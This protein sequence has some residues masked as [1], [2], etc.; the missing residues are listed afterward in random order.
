MNNLI[1]IARQSMAYAQCCNL[2][3]IRLSSPLLPVYVFMRLYWD[4]II[5]SQ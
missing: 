1:N 4:T 2:L 3:L 5:A